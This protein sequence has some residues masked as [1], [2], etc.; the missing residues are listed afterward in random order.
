MR[1]DI[2]PQP[3]EG[4]ILQLAAYCLLVE[5]RFGKP[6]RRGQ[7]LYQNRSLEVNQNTAWHREVD[8]DVGVVPA[9]YDPTLQQPAVAWGQF[10]EKGAKSVTSRG[11]HWGRFSDHHDDTLTRR[12]ERNC[13]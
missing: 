12:A 1:R 2:H 5:E 8:G 3:Y 6:V 10:P 9:V 4:E 13:V 7:L 11:S